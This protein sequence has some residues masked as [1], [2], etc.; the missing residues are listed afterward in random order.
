MS[1]SFLEDIKNWE[2]VGAGATAVGVI[3]ALVAASITYY[4]YRGAKEIQRETTAKQI[5]S[6]YLELAIQYPNLTSGIMPSDLLEYERYEW[7]VS[8]MLNVFEHIL[9]AV[10]NDEEWRKTVVGQ[11]E[12]HQ[13]YFLNDAEFK[14]EDYYYYDPKIRSMI[15]KVCGTNK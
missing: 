14:A 7:F 12:Y 11:I 8:F 15:D 4:Q 13:D 6:N 5:Y 9:N 3:V 10:G 2:D 1:L